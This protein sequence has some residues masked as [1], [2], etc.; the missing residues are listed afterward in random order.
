MAKSVQKLAKSS[1]VKKPK[2]ITYSKAKKDLWTV[3]SLF[4]RL[5]GCIET[6][7]TLDIGKCFTCEREYA[8]KKLQAGHWIPGRH[9]LVLF[10]VRNTH[11]Q[12]YHCNVGLK[13]NPVV[14]YDKMLAVYGKDICEELKAKD[15]PQDK[16]YTVAE[17]LVMKEDFEKKIEELKNSV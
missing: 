15:K 4:I 13:G 16:Q 9:I 12:C 7:G 17:L 2:K 11:P 8:I 5:T 6:T 3:Y 1:K 14:Y 10:D